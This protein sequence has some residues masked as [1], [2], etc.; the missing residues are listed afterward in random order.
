METSVDASSSSSGIEPATPVLKCSATDGI[1]S[2]RGAAVATSGGIA[3]FSRS[4]RYHRPQP[5]RRGAP[6]P[7]N[8][9]VLFPDLTARATNKMANM[10]SPHA[11]TAHPNPPRSTSHKSISPTATMTCSCIRTGRISANTM[12]F[13]VTPTFSSSMSGN[14]R[15]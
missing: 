9:R 7:S 5:F 4:G 8:S 15:A 14:V 1:C 11:N 3:S 12:E 10:C 13:S 6:R 2:A